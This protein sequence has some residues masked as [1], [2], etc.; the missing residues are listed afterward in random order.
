MPFMVSGVAV[1]KPGSTPC[2]K[3]KFDSI[4]FK[5]AADHPDLEATYLITGAR[6]YKFTASPG[7]ISPEGQA[8]RFLFPTRRA[9]SGTMMTYSLGPVSIE[10]LPDK[11]CPGGPNEDAEL[12]ISIKVKEVSAT[13][14]ANGR[15]LRSAAQEAVCQIPILSTA[16]KNLLITKLGAKSNNDLAVKLAAKTGLAKNTVLNA[17]KGGNLRPKTNAAL[18][19][20]L[21]GL[22]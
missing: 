9:G 20:L 7:K 3:G 4:Q 18:A 6:R 14:A 22:K 21:K 13:K 2:Q 19:K 10:R 15:R 16:L 17:L 8:T 5:A 1:S 12:V 11:P